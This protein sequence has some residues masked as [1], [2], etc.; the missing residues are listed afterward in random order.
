MEWGLDGVEDINPDQV[1]FTPQQRRNQ[2]TPQG[3]RGNDD[4]LPALRED[5]L[6]EEDARSETTT[7]M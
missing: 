1:A 4:D 7:Q 3:Q 6:R 5:P 2:E